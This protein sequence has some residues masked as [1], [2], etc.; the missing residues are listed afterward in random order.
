MAIKSCAK[1]GKEAELRL[2][3]KDS[4][5]KD[6]LSCHC[7]DC[8]QQKNIKYIAAN[9]DKIKQYQANFYQT[10]KESV[11][12]QTRKYKQD[13]KDLV[14]VRNRK[15]LA[16]RRQDPEFRLKMNLRSR[17][18]GVLKKK[19]NIRG[20]LIVE[21]IGCSIPELKVHLESQFTEGMS[22]DNYGIGGWEVDH[23]QP[24]SKANSRE[25]FIQLSHYSNL[26]PLW[27]ED[28]RKKGSK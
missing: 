9:S 12:E 19:C 17:V 3:C 16:R 5:K 28:N 6:G 18:S 8:R 7:F 25:E 27:S 15:Y 13:N 11:L 14:R 20:S 4:S 2:F 1:C 23:I 26:R 22:W 24:I 21:Y 10:N